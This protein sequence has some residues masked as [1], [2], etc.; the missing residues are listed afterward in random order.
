ML[1]IAIMLAAVGAI[2]I[3][4]GWLALPLVGMAVAAVTVAVT[5][6]TGRLSQS[7]CL[8]CGEDLRDRGEG[9][10]GLICPACGSVN[11]Q[12]PGAA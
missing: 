5:R 6:M 3:G 11:Q 8:T 1:V 9:E 7:V 2:S 4:P 10:H 12:G